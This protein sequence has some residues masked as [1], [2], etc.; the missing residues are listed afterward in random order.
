[1]MQTAH[2]PDRRDPL[3]IVLDEGGPFHTR[4]RYAGY[5]ERLRETGR[6]EQAERLIARE[7]DLHPGAV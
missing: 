5:V 1:M 4:G 6:D 3:H 2:T 7:A